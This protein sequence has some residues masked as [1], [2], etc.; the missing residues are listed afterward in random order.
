MDATSDSRFTA[1]DV[2]YVSQFLFRDPRMLG[3]PTKPEE[4]GHEPREAEKTGREKRGFPPEP[5]RD[6]RHQPGRGDH[7]DVAAAVEDAGGRRTLALRKPVGDS[8]DGR[9]EVGR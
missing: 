1:L 9:R 3:G 4:P 5:Q 8:A 6:E 7:A 2:E